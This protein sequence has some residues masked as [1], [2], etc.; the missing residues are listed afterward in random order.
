MLQKQ[1]LKT[2]KAQALETLDAGTFMKKH[3]YPYASLRP[4]SL[5]KIYVM[6]GRNR[7]VY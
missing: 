4:T 3:R 1:E 7:S 5:A 2:V 6:L